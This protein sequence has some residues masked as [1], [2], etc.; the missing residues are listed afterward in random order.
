M[1]IKNLTFHLE[2]PLGMFFIYTRFLDDAKTLSY[3]R[4]EIYCA[5]GGEFWRQGDGGYLNVR[6]EFTSEISNVEPR[7]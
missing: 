1:F 7:I 2:E 6:I 5:K 3:P 4:Y